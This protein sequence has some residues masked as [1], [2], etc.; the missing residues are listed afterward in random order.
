MNTDLIAIS[1]ITVPAGRR[2]LDP[3]WVETLA[4][5]MADPQDCSPIEVIE[6]DGALQLVFGAHRLAAARRNGWPSIPGRVRSPMEFAHEAEIKLREITENMARRELSA[7][8]RA[9]DI[10]QWREVYEA[11]HG[12]VK[13][14]RPSKLAQVA[15]ISDAAEE[16]FAT[17]F[18]AAAQRAL[19]ISRDAIKRAMRIASIRADVRERLSLHP[20]ADNQSELLQLAGEGPERQAQIAALMTAEPAQAGTVAEAIA[21]LDRAPKPARIERWQKLSN[22][23]SALKDKEQHAFFDLHAEAIERWLKERSS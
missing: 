16:R 20:I 22:V 14:G 17:S 7:L 18:S 23:F 9:V 6:R 4:E 15:P 11:V 5:M 1:A 2:R 21:F 13:K 19:G 10:A 12:A 3:A 8:D